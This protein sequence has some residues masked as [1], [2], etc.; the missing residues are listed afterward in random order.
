MLFLPFR[1]S[2]S[3][4]QWLFLLVI[5]LCVSLLGTCMLC[6][7]AFCWNCSGFSHLLLQRC[8]LVLL[9]PYFLQKAIC[10]AFC[11]L[12]PLWLSVLFERKP[13]LLILTS[14][15]PAKQKTANRI[16]SS[17]LVLF[18]LCFLFQKTCLTLSIRIH[19]F[20]EIFTDRWASCQPLSLAC[21]CWGDACTCAHHESLLYL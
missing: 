9:G 15:V 3:H 4:W 18:L 19:L 10:V 7:L 20:G 11:G 1:A 13:Q 12:F 6:L 17:L 21:L 16:W 14:L 2:S 5:G 8:L